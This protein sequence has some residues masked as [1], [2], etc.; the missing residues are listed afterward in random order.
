VIITSANAA[1]YVAQVKREAAAVQEKI[2][3]LN[4]TIATREVELAIV[5]NA[6]TA[7]P[8]LMALP[9]PAEVLS[10]LATIA[11]GVE[12]AAKVMGLK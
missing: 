11:L 3:V 6:L 9:L 5:E 12:T 4:A 2:D 7:L 1:E 10:L 8:A